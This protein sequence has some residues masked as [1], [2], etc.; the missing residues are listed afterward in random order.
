MN[1]RRELGEALDGALAPGSVTVEGD[2]RRAEVDVAEVDRLGVRVRTV[3]VTV[4]RSGNIVQQAER[5]PEACRTLPERIV[6]VEVAP[7]LGGA[8][9]RSHPRDIVDREFFEVQTDGRS[10]TIGRVNN[11]PEGRVAVPFTVTR[12]QLR[13]LVDDI[14][15]AMEPQLDDEPAPRRPVAGAWR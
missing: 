6:P 11:G 8:V 9:L 4:A 7:T 15:E 13:R 14:G 12:E 3:R 10:A 2:G 5:L 1:V